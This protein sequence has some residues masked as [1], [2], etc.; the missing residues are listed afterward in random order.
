MDFD[1]MDMA[2]LILTA[3]AVA[4]VAEGFIRPKR[5]GL[6]PAI[7]PRCSQ[8]WPQRE[9]TDAQCSNAPY[10]ADCRGDGPSRT[11]PDSTSG[12]RLSGAA[13][14]DRGRLRPRRHHRCDRPHPGAEAR[15][16]LQSTRLQPAIR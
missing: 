14:A 12:R 6:W 11:D 3:D 1:T 16:D 5:A 2:A 4:V 8:N 10:R 15:P 9:E 7:A 13:G